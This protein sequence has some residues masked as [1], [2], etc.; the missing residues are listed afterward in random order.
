MFHFKKASKIARDF[1]QKE[2]DIAAS[3]DQLDDITQ[4][5]AELARLYLSHRN[6]LIGATALT[7]LSISAGLFFEPAL[8]ALPVGLGGMLFFGCTTWKSEQ[9]LFEAAGFPSPN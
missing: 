6:W 4:D 1:N 5:N 9:H 3:F 7:L 2:R 8:I